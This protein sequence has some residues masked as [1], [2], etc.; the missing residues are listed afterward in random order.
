MTHLPPRRK[1][2]PMGCKEPTKRVYAAH[3]AFV[4]RHRCSVQG[5]PNE[6]SV[7]AHVRS[8]RDGGT[9]IKPHDAWCISLCREH[10]DQQH[11]IGERSFAKLHGID[12][13]GL[14]K[15]FASRSPVAEIR[16][17]ALIKMQEITP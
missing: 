2:P 4:R 6:P 12:L 11:N 7:A 10:H 14:A 3:K 15:A 13:L 17:Y 1:R 8:S 16:E 5:C 9:Q